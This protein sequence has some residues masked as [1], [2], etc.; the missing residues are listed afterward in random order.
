MSDFPRSPGRRALQRHSLRGATRDYIA[1]SSAMLRSTRPT[2]QFG[3]LTISQEGRLVRCWQLTRRAI[4]WLRFSLLGWVFQATAQF[5]R[6]APNIES[7][8]AE[9]ARQ[10]SAPKERLSATLRLAA[11]MHFRGPRAHPSKLMPPRCEPFLLLI[12][13]RNH[14]LAIQNRGSAHLSVSS[15]NS[16]V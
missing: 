10:T 1:W 7:E 8:T 6:C 16:S 3:R 5:L 11:W 4:C 14:G 15:E 12:I 2:S 13:F 9:L